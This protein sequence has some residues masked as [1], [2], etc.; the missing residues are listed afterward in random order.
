MSSALADL[1]QNAAAVS[2]A[3]RASALPATVEEA[4]LKAVFGPEDKLVSVRMACDTKGV[5]CGHA[6]LD[7]DSPEAATRALKLHKGRLIP[8]HR[9][10]LR[11]MVAPAVSASV[12]L[13]EFQLCVGNLAE[14][15]THSDL[16]EALCSLVGGVLG[17]RVPMDAARDCPW[18]YAFVR[19]SNF[20]YSYLALQRIEGFVFAGRRLTVRETY[21]QGRPIGDVCENR[22]REVR[23]VGDISSTSI[24][25]GGLHVDF[26]ERWIR[27][28]FESF[29]VIVSVRLIPSHCFGFIEFVEHSAGLAALSLMQGREIYG[30][31]VHLRWAT[32]QEAV[33]NPRGVSCN[34]AAFPPSREEVEDERD[35]WETAMRPSALPMTGQGVPG[36]AM[37]AAD[38]AYWLSRCLLPTTA[39]ATAQVPLRPVPTMTAVSSELVPFGP[40][41]APIMLTSSEQAPSGPVSAP[42]QVVT[43]EGDISIHDGQTAKRPRVEVVA[44][45]L[46]GAPTVGELESAMSSR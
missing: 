18:G 26:T 27:T 2:R 22:A 39:A 14:S 21:V 6:L 46:E 28:T 11:L 7:F 30:R 15:V 9:A 32:P 37:D 8:R 12:V 25:I 44:L 23:K 43:A 40:A 36:A 24:F 13:E 41:P 17:V 45:T 5:C 38:K 31:R 33:F 29:G 42:V 35:D 19:F 20:E 4:D 1:P 16:Y 34:V 3:L 10:R